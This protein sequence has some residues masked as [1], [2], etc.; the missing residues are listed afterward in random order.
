MKVGDLVRIKRAAVGYRDADALGLCISNEWRKHSI[1]SKIWIVEIIN[2]ALGRSYPYFE[3][4]L[5]L[6]SES[7]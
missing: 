1:E 4:E 3:E 6:V 5:E 2:P 7:R